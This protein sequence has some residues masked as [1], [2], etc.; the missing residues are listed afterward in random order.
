MTKEQVF[1]LLKSILIDTFEFDESEITPTANLNEELDIDSIDAVDIMV[2]IKEVT[3]KKMTAEDFQ[4]VRT[5]GDV[6][7]AVYQ[8]VKN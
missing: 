2:K 7:D 1:E 4:N 8:L 5:V 6:V 3:G